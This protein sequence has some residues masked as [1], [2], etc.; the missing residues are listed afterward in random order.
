MLA[1]LWSL[2]S[3][4]RPQRLGQKWS[5]KST[6]WHPCCESQRNPDRKQ[7]GSDLE[8][9]RPPRFCAE[10]TSTTRTGEI[11]EPAT[12]LNCQN[13]LQQEEALFNQRGKSQNIPELKHS[14]LGDLHV[15]TRGAHANWEREGDNYSVS[16]QP[17]LCPMPS[18]RPKFSGA[19]QRVD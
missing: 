19:I 4:H 1:W 9:S 11:K 3:T 17:L 15:V 7:A 13:H 12:T 18:S 14:I 2:F 10:Q 16:S 8:L 5:S 6:E